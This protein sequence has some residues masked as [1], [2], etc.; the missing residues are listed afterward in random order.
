MRDGAKIKF[1]LAGGSSFVRTFP[2]MTN[3]Q[4]LAHCAP[5]SFGLRSVL[6]QAGHFTVGGTY[7][8]LD[9]FP[10]CK[11]EIFNSQNDNFAKIWRIR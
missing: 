7:E 4:A 1:T 3:E 2:N 8:W 11:V 10:A 9:T 5:D 6:R